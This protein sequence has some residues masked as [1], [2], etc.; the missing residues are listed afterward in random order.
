MMEKYGNLN[1]IN[2]NFYG[3][4]NVAHAWGFSLLSRHAMEIQLEFNLF[5][6][7]VEREKC[8]EVPLKVNGIFFLSGEVSSSVYIPSSTIAWMNRKTS[9]KI[10]LPFA[11]QQG[12][13]HGEEEEENLDVYHRRY[14]CVH[15]KQAQRGTQKDATWVLRRWHEKWRISSVGHFF[16]YVLNLSCFMFCRQQRI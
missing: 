6:F 8:E 16:I 1:V 2:H 14:V 7:N 4:P 5:A 12:R 9:G 10:T 15:D 3:D 11:Q 13:K